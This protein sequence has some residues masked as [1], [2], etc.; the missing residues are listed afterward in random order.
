M[1]AH[2]NYEGSRGHPHSP[3]LPL[4]SADYWVAF[5]LLFFLMKAVQHD[6]NVA[7]Q[8]YLRGAHIASHHLSAT[9]AC[10]LI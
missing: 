10:A 6:G 2:C 8:L 9:S 7:Q 4:M 3:Q 1:Y 5:L